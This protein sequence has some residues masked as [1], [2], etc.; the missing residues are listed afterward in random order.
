MDNKKK[1]NQDGI[2]KPN[3]VTSTTIIV[4]TCNNNK[5]PSKI[6][7]IPIITVADINKTA[8]KSNQTGQTNRMGDN[9]NNNGTPLDN[10]LIFKIITAVV[11]LTK[12]IIINFNSDNNLII[13]LVGVKVE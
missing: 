2:A 9:N 4:I 12:L 8:I 11:D 1:K 3:P 7:I 13:P 6:T 10:N 5:P